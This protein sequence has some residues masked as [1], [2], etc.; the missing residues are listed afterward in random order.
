MKKEFLAELIA[1]RAAKFPTVVVTNL[2]SGA[3]SGETAVSNTT[4][5]HVHFVRFPNIGTDMS[6]VKDQI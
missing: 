3:Q 4:F 2:S 6:E 5:F 1:A